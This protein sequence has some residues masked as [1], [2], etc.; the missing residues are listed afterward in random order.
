M[1]ECLRVC[2]NVS[3]RNFQPARLFELS[4]RFGFQQ[5]GFENFFE[6]AAPA[7]NPGLNGAD[8]ALQNFR[9]FFVAEAFEV[10]QNH[11]A[12]KS[13]G[14]LAQR[15]LHGL[16]NFVRGELLEG[17]IETFFCKWRLNQRFWFK[18][19]RIAIR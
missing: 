10:A 17:R 6:R 2:L 11:G 5:H 16:L 19:S 13:L 7:K 1:N 18:A 8:A 3:Q 9:D 15:A 14:N 4:F 12:A